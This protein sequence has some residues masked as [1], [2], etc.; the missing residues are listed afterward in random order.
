MRANVGR[1]NTI[2]MLIC[3]EYP[4]NNRKD[5]KNT[6]FTTLSSA[7]SRVLLEKSLLGSV[8]RSS[9]QFVMIARLRNS[10]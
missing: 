6:K 1:F 9:R 7:T 4:G 2:G 3:N 10:F 8:C 5:A